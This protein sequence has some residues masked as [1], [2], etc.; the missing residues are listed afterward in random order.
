VDFI[1]WVNLVDNESISWDRVVSYEA[2]NIRETGYDLT[3]PGSE[4]FMAVD[5]TIL[6]N[7]VQIHV[8]V[9]PA[10]VEDSKNITLSHLLFSDRNPRSL[11]IAP[12]MESIM[13]L[14]RATRPS[15]DKK[16]KSFASTE[17]ALG[18]YHRGELDLNDPVKI[19]K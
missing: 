19:D 5:G 4:T 17:E 16:T 12:E 18:A 6:S 10:A 9:T 15:S 1:P 13:G 14:H 11:N 3:V 2:T 7:T 8:P